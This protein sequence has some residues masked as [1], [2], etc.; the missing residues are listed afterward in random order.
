[1]K[2]YPLIIAISLFLSLA[3]GIGLV[4]PKYQ[5]LRALEEKIRDKKMEIASQEEYFS[6]LQKISEQLKEYQVPLAKIG[7][8]LPQN[9]SLPQ[10]L[11]FFQKTGSQSG[12]VLKGISPAFTVPVEGISGVRQTSL[13]LALEGSYPSF[14]DFLSILENSARLIELENISFSSPKEGPFT[15]NIRIK[16]YSY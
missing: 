1:M 5:E 10:L 4:L 15:F 7:Q 16:V 9:P 13:S 11:D 2:N 12:L 14:K 6:D 3:L 8:A